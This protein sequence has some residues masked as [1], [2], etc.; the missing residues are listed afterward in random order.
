MVLSIP[1]S[2]HL[3]Y[4]VSR[5]LFSRIP[6]NSRPLYSPVPAP[7]TP[8]FPSPWP[9]PPK[10]SKREFTTGGNAFYF[11]SRFQLRVVRAGKRSSPVDYPGTSQS[12]AQS[13][14]QSPQAL[15]SAGRRLVRL[16]GNRIFIEFF[17]WLLVEQ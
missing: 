12:R 4:P 14:T 17:D 9:P 16:W 6:Y 11:R 10:E 3:E 1:V 7:F 5:P 2:R 8:R 15:W 13:R